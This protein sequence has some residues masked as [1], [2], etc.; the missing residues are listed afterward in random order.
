MS[1][2]FKTVTFLI[3]ETKKGNILLESAKNDKIKIQKQIK[4]RA[5][6]K[7][8]SNRFIVFSIMNK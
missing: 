7:K 1:V 8:K 3:V 2:I 6:M 4:E 5:F